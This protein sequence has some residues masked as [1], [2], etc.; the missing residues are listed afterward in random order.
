MYIDNDGDSGEITWASIGESM[1]N[2]AS[3]AADG[4]FEVNAVGGKALL[5]AIGRMQDW[6]DGQSGDLRYLEQELPLGT[7]H[8]A[9]I[10]K[11]YVQQVATDKQGFLTVLR[12]FRE[13]LTKAEQGIR[14]AMA[15]Y[16]ATEEANESTLCKGGPQ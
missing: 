1:A 12:Q 14:T 7:S 11:P 13:S 5:G 9:Q 2:F 8:A 15:N 4:S 3:M 6:V 16:Q 10:M